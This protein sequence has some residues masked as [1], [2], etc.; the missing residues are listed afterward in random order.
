LTAADGVT[1]FEN[2]DIARAP[3]MY[4]YLSER[5]DGFVDLGPL[6]AT[7]RSFQLP[8]SGRLGSGLR[9]IG[10]RLVPRLLG[11]VRRPGLRP[12]NLPGVSS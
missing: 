5:I 3:N 9:Q 10:G 6:K 4:V 12:P 7:N 11:H 1:R 8:G 2:F